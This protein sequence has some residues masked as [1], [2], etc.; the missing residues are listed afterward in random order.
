MC[1]CACVCARVCVCVHTRM[2]VHNMCTNTSL[3]RIPHPSPLIP[4]V[5]IHLLVPL[6]GGHSYSMWTEFMVCICVCVCVCVC[7]C[8]WVEAIAT[9]CGLSSW[10]VHVFVRARACVCVC[11]WVGIPV[12][13][14][15][16]GVRS[17]VL[18]VQSLNTTHTHTHPPALPAP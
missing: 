14:M 9:P 15:I 12:L 1:M 3:T 7:V 8:G 2:R 5:D 10:Y 17:T 4:Q 11:G 13:W 6:L 16:L 18:A